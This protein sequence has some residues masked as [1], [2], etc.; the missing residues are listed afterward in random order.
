MVKKNL[1]AAV[2]IALLMCGVAQAAT[3]A[4]APASSAASTSKD[5]P[6]RTWAAQGQLGLI[7]SRGNTVTNS[8]N[9][10]FDAAHSVGRWLF[11]GGFAALYASTNGITTQQDTTGHLQSNLQLSKRT[12]WFANAMYDRNL[13]T[14]FAYQ[15]SVASGAGYNFIA[16]PATQ[17]SAE[18]GAGYRRQEPEFLT[19]NAL[20][21]IISRS[22]TPST[23]CPACGTAVSDAVLVAALKYEHTVTATTKLL[24]S[25]QVLS[26][27]SDTL[28]T[29]NLS[30]QVKVDASLSLAVGVQLVNNTNPP[31]GNVRHTDTVMTVNL[32]YALKNSKLSPTAT[33]PLLSDVNMFD[34]P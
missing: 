26:A 25:L 27:S 5:S 9:A 12:F 29:D 4:A 7:V 8:G 17:L 23:E 21:G 6:A 34:L 3:A 11:I 33:A 28:T 30:L 14:G 32:V 22:R 31:P 19:K 10:S 13:F 24:N 15:E 16:T 20:G 1:A 2:G 18:L